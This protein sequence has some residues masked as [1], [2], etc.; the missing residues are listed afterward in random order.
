LLGALDVSYRA[1]IAQGFGDLDQ[2][3]MFDFLLS[4]KSHA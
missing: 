3:A 2:S 4:S 1:A